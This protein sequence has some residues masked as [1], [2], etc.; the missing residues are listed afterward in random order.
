[1]TQR[2]FPFDSTGIANEGDWARI[3]GWTQPT[4]VRYGELNNFALG[5]TSGLNQGIQSG[6]SFMDGVWHESDATVTK[7]HA[8]NAPNGSIRIDRIA[9]K[10]DYT[11][12]T[13]DIVIVPGTPGAGIPA[14]TDTAT[15]KYSKLYR[16]QL[17]ATSASINST[18]DERDYCNRPRWTVVGAGSNPAF[19]NSWVQYNSGGYAD[20][21]Y[22]LDPNGFV[23]LRGL[24]KSGTMGTAIFTLPAGYQPA[25]KHLFAAA[26]NTAFDYVTV[27]AAGAVVPETVSG[28]SNGWVSL[29]GISFG[30]TT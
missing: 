9:L 19:E 6:R 15:V 18:V 20:V 8:T 14:L 24:C 2:S 11:S 29:D 25:Y 27:S 21:A 12:N 4:G 26:S 5:T 30:V 10:K 13:V 22:Y 16:V 17:N 23:H 1:M 7:T 3:L 28:A